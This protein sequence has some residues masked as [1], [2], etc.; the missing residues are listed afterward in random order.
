MVKVHIYGKADHTEIYVQRAKYKHWFLV[1]HHKPTD[2]AFRD[3]L[4]KNEVEWKLI[5]PKLF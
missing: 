5:E 4:A 2:I 3:A 1:G